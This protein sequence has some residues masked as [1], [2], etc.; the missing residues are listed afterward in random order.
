MFKEVPVLRFMALTRVVRLLWSGYD[1][2]NSMAEYFLEGDQTLENWSSIEESLKLKISNCLDLPN[3]L[4]IVLSSLVN[5]IGGRIKN[6]IQNVY[7]NYYLPSHF[8]SILKWTLLGT[9][10]AKK[11]AEAVI[12]DNNLPITKRYE[13]ACTYCL[14]EEI[15]MLWSE[16]HKTDRNVHLYPWEPVCPRSYF[17]IYRTCYMRAELEKLDREIR[18]VYNMRLSSH[19]FGVLC[20]HISVNRPALE[21]FYGTLSMTE[22]EEYLECFFKS[23]SFR[24]VTDIYLCDIIYFVLSQ[25]I[26]NQR[27][28]IFEK[29]AYHILNNLLEF[30]F[31]GIF[32]EIESLVQKYLTVDQ[33]KDLEGRYKETCRY[34]LFRTL[35]RNLRK[36]P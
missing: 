26:E 3:E 4:Q 30:P 35:D 20:A 28:S 23:V 16:L 27:T 10:D 6:I 12:K 11:T 9:I 5:P 14:K 36:L 22:K 29:Y 24:L 32:L 31:G 2:Q 7:S 8:M 34:F 15:L 13:I 1:V 21:Y 18:E 19:C 33:V 25:V 17:S